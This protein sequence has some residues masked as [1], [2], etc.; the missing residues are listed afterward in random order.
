[1]AVK[2]STLSI[3]HVPVIRMENR[4]LQV[5]IAPLLGGKIISLYNKPLKHE[6]LWKNKS[7]PLQTYPAG[8]EYD[9]HF[10]GGIDELLPNDI[11]ETID[12]ITYPDH[13]ELWT[14]ILES[15]IDNHSVV[16]KNTLPLSGLYY[17]KVLRLD[18][19]GPYV[20]TDYTIRNDSTGK[21]HFLWKL[22]GALSIQPGDR[23]ECPALSAQVAD[24]QYS[25]FSD[26]T[27]FTWPI[28][29]N[30]NAAIIPAPNGSMDFFYLLDLQQGRMQWISHDQTK[31]FS[32][33]FDTK[34]FPYA[35]Y[36]ASYGGFLGHYTAVLEPCTT[37]PIVMNE[38]IEKGQCSV[39]GAGESI[40]TTVTM[41]AGAYKQE[42]V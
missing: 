18:E 41:F 19:A 25:R 11:P 24:P 17:E 30:T 37:M 39:L 29:E 20:H 4:W 8:T 9:P 2:L 7:L 28:I 22:H 13:G 42:N 6:F 27:P 34:I 12:G 35:W 32:Y 26:T 23:I 1:M 36:F 38:A 21:R 3:N 15:A 40:Q 16:L 31:Q 10:Y 33:L 14:T 5:D